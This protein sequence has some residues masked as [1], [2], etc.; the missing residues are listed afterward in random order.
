MAEGAHIRPGS[1]CIPSAAAGGEV[2]RSHE[3]SGAKPTPGPEVTPTKGGKT[4]TPLH[5]RLCGCSFP[6]CFS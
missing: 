6:F 4:L 1:L 3:L 2:H 5:Q